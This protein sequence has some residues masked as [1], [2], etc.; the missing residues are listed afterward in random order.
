MPHGLFSW[1]HPSDLSGHLACL[2][3]FLT[4]SHICPPGQKCCFKSLSTKYCCPTQ[5]SLGDLG[6]RMVMA[7]TFPRGMA[8]ISQT[9]PKHTAFS[10][11]LTV[12]FISVLQH[13]LARGPQ[14]PLWLEPCCNKTDNKDIIINNHHARP[15]GLPA[16][17]TISGLLPPPALPPA[18]GDQDGEIVP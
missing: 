17:S 14:G 9:G 12:T 10:Q 13:K 18:L 1:L 7:L 6:L 2:P 11:P 4:P 8:H 5:P 3:A 15:Q 16:S